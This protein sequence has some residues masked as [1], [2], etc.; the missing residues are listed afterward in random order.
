MTK[1]PWW[2][3]CLL[4]AALALPAA[5]QEV[6]FPPDVGKPGNDPSSQPKPVKAGSCKGR[7]C[8]LAIRVNA[9]CDISIDQQW[10]FIA[11]RNVQILWEIHPADYSFPEQG[12]IEFKSEYNPLWREEFYDGRRLSPGVW[13][14]IDANNTPD[15]YR[16]TATV[17]HNRT[18]KVC[19]IDPGV[20]NDWP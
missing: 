13:Q 19:T 16:Y 2:S 17:V 4:V 18:G 14:W 12:G 5:A 8:T 15:V 20:V 7:A 6:V 3:A 10:V 11:G 9:N 1:K